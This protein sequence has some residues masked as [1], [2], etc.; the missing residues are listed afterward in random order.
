MRILQVRLEA[1]L[2]RSDVLG[3]LVDTVCPLGVI[4]LGRS[5]S[6]GISSGQVLGL[7]GIER[8]CG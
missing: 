4:W 7:T 1:D 5:L 3:E 6:E 8:H 2:D